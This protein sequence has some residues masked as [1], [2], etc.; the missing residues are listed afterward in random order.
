[1]RTPPKIHLAPCSTAGDTLSLT[2]VPDLRQT[3]PESALSLPLP[4]LATAR[5]FAEQF[6][7][8]VQTR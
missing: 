2:P 5:A 7:K 1:M 4:R 8:P 6:D 3:H